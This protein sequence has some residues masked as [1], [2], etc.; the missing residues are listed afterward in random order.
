MRSELVSFMDTSETL[1][2][3]IM[4]AYMKVKKFNSFPVFELLKQRYMLNC[5]TAVDAKL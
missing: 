5:D 1:Y 2:D 4:N 3:E